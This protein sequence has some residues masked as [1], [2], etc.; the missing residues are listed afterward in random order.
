MAN[1]EKLKDVAKKGKKRIFFFHHSKIK[2]GLGTENFD[3]LEIDDKNTDDGITENIKRKHFTD[4]Y[5][6]K[7]GR[8]G[9]G[10]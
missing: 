10:V 2:S 8:E 7:Y 4:F 9:G 6:R 5:V 1:N 3:G